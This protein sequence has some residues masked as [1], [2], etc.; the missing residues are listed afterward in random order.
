MTQRRIL[1]LLICGWIAA[2]LGYTQLQHE[3]EQIGPRTALVTNH[4]TGEVQNC[5]TYGYSDWSCLPADIAPRSWVF[6]LIPFW[7]ARDD[8]GDKL[9]LS[10]T[11]AEDTP[12]KE[13][14][15]YSDLISNG[16]I[17]IVMLVMGI[18]I[19][20]IRDDE[21]VGDDSGGGSD[22]GGFSGE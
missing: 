16:V 4:F 9:Y 6:A 2:L 14:P 7:P 5:D 15:L 17:G 1:L 13:T 3:V 20:R 8:L 18:F 12:F 21:E 10:E 22:G 11:W 19:M